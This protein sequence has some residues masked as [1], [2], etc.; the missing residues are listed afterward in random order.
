MEGNEER[1]DVSF[2]PQESSVFLRKVVSSLRKVETLGKRVTALEVFDLG[3][4]VPPLLP[5]Y[6]LH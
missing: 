4:Y 2:F 5:R 3:S 1:P 6:N